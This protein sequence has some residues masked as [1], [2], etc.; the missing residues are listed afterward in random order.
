M[1]GKNIKEYLRENGLKQSYLAEKVGITSC[2]MSRICNNDAGIDCILYYRICRE[3]NVP[4]EYFMKGV[5][6]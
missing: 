2:A 6:A 1:V 5:E 3:L 4:F